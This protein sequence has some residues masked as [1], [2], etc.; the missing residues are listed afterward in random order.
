MSLSPDTYID[1]ITGLPVCNEC[2]CSIE[3][4]KCLC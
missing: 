4:G 2:E 1:P 3:N